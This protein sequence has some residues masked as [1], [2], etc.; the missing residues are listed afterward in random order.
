M[1]KYITKEEFEQLKDI[2]AYKKTT[3]ETGVT[4]STSS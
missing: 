3:N 4:L 1:N 2:V